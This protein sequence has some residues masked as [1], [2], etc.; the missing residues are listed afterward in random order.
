MSQKRQLEAL[1]GAL[2]VIGH[3]PL[4]QC[5]PVIDAA[6]WMQNHALMALDMAK[7]TEAADAS[8][9]IAKQAELDTANARI[10]ELERL[11]E[12]EQRH[13]SE[14]MSTINELRKGKLEASDA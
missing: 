3:Y 4:P 1:R 2:S 9:L 13:G 5:P 8:L 12:A 10:A 11:L 14:L 6:H 7:E